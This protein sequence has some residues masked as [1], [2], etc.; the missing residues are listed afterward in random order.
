MLTSAARQSKATFI[1]P[2]FQKAWNKYEIAYSKQ[3]IDR[4]KKL[5]DIYYREIARVHAERLDH[6]TEMEK[7]WKDLSSTMATVKRL[8]DSLTELRKEKRTF[9]K[10]VKKWD[11]NPMMLERRYWTVNQLNARI[12]ELQPLTGS[13]IGM[14]KSIYDEF[15]KLKAFTLKCLNATKYF[16]RID[17]TLVELSYSHFNSLKTIMTIANQIIQRLYRGRVI[18]MRLYLVLRDGEC[19]LYD[20]YVTNMELRVSILGFVLFQYNQSF[21]IQDPSA[22][23]S[24]KFVMY[25]GQ[26]ILLDRRTNDEQI[27][28]MC[29][30]LAT[31]INNGIR[32]IVLLGNLSVRNV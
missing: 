31:C 3:Q 25:E 13:S 6:F 12:L 17:R 19:H 30:Y 9:L 8:E 11:R 29:V 21:C 1:T 23:V 10:N 4:N 5:V 20:D 32:P 18:A 7:S 24:L 2:D 22:I 28:A 27:M 14:Q 16:A 26:Q 15:K